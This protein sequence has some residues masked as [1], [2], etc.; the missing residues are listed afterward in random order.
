MLKSFSIAPS[1]Y[2][3]YEITYNQKQEEVIG[4]L[5]HEKLKDKPFQEKFGLKNSRDKNFFITNEK[6][7]K[8]DVNVGILRL[9]KM[10]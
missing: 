6:N 9:N 3:K 2:D 10:F 7:L 1:K 8:F 4:P 5:R